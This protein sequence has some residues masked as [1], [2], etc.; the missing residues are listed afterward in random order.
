MRGHLTF[1]I[2]P[3]A[4]LG[5]AAEGSGCT[6]T[7]EPISPPGEDGGTRVV[8]SR[9]RTDGAPPSNDV[10]PQPVPHRHRPAA[11]SCAPTPLPAEPT[12]V[13]PGPTGDAGGDTTISRECVIH[14][15]CTEAPNGRCVAVTDCNPSTAT[16][17]TH[18]VY[19]QCEQDDDCGAGSACFCSDDKTFCAG[20]YATSCSL[21]ASGYVCACGLANQCKKGNCRV[22]SDCGHR[23]YCS[24]ALDACGAVL[25][26]YCHTAE[27]EC[28]NDEECTNRDGGPPGGYLGCLPDPNTM[29]RWVCTPL[30]QCP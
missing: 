30:A 3:I 23:G 5:M 26:Y 9:A 28:V 1:A 8:D 22:D 16:C 29:S 2:I 27:D 18:C 24:P 15:D 19:E 14:A 21:L 20:G 12:S 6:T 11:S 13:P 17:G 4:I 7:V 25:G 10:A